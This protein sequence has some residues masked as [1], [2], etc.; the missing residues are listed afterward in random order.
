MLS[1]NGT[2]FSFFDIINL[3]KTNIVFENLFSFLNIF[4]YEFR[5]SETNWILPERWS[6]G[7]S[8]EKTVCNIY[9]MG[10]LYMCTA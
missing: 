1:K 5:Y 2:M 10:L 3:E 4:S 7:P 8:K 9:Y 6:K